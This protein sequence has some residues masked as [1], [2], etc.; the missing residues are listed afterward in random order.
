MN[1][2]TIKLTKDKQI[3]SYLIYSLEFIELETVKIYIR[4]N[5]ANAFI[6]PFKFL[7]GVFI[8]FDQK[9]NRNFYFY[10]NY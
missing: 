7:A 4:T 8:L 6:Q 5:L 3:S 10:M 2:Y 1:D 9:P